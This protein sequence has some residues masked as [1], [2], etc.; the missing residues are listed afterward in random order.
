MRL[1]IHLPRDLREWPTMIYHVV[2]SAV[3]DLRY[4]GLLMGGLTS[5][6]A[7]QGA[8]EVNNSDYGVLANVFRGRISDDDVLVDLGC[9]KGRVI[10]A[11]LHLGYQN[12]M[13]GVELDPEV[14]ARTRKRLA[15][16]DNVT[17]ITGDA[18][19][20]IPTDGTVF[21]LYNPF[22]RPV[23]VRLKS[24]LEALFPKGSGVT[25]LYL[26]AE[27]ADVFADDPKWNVEMMD[28]STSKWNPSPPLA[29]I[30]RA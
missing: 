8:N 15:R 16:F 19:E 9:G 14:A 1:S 11:W 4:G 17:I 30:T 10:N 6:Y 7:D 3:L 25:L 29:V 13:V 26:K 12:P 21:F 20:Y 2:Y 28:V 27:H 24:R 5:R 18:I 22:D 23:W